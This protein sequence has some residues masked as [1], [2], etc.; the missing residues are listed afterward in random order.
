LTERL[1]STARPVRG[2]AA[3]LPKSLE[4]ED[5]LSRLELVVKEL[6]EELVVRRARE[7]AMQAELDHLWARVKIGGG[8]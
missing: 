1:D 3:E 4:L 6:R 8:V 7:I 2:T 5:R